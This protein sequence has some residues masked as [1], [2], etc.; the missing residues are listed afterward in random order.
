[1]PPRTHAR[2]VAH[3][4]AGLRRGDA[5]AANNLAVSYRMA[6]NWRR[7]YFWWRRAA[8]PHS[9]DAWLEVGFCLQYGLGVRR[10]LNRAIR[11]YRSAARTYYTTA[12]GREEALYHLAVALLDRGRP[13]D[14]PAV[15]DCLESAAADGDYPQAV[16]LLAG[17][18]SRAAVVACRCRRFLRRRFGGKQQ[19]V[20][21]RMPGRDRSHNRLP[22]TGGRT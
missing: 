16:A 19:C 13:S 14:L 6:G 20:I 4:R 7:A 18:D 21:H 12:N 1:M 5:L 3:L 10:D 17:L 22:T 11:A 2:E 15:R 9:G 8:G